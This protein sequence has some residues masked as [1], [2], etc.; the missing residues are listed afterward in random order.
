MA[1]TWE[2]H[3]D[4]VNSK[5]ALRA[6]IEAIYQCNFEVGEFNIEHNDTYRLVT[7]D[8]ADGTF[9]VSMDFEKIDADSPEDV[10]EFKFKIVEVI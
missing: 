1:P 6:L 2:G 9:M 8:P 10:T 4:L 7:F 5:Q 3:G